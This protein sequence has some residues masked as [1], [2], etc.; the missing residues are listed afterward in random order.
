MFLSRHGLSITATNLELDDGEI[1]ILAMDG[2]TSV[3]L[4]IRTTSGEDDPIDAID[5]AKR[6]R[7]KWLARRIGADR[8]DFVGVR[9]G[10]EGLDFHWVPGSN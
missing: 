6:K 7:V 10:C 2:G 1:D 4:E 3:A 5:H 9:V 8:V